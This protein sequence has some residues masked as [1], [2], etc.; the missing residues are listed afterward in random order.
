M[1][2]ITRWYISIYIYVCMYVRVYDISCGKANTK[3]YPPGVD[4]VGYAD[5]DGSCFHD[6]QVNGWLT[7]V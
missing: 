2:V 5:M 6:R 3:P 4:I 1:L 7:A